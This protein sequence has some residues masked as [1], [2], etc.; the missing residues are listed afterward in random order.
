MLGNRNEMSSDDSSWSLRAL[1]VRPPTDD[2]WGIILRL[3]N[4]SVAHVPDAGP[5]DEWLENRR[6]FDRSKGTQVQ[7]VAEE[8]STHTILGYGA[9]ELRRDRDPNGCRLFVVAS[10]G[11]LSSVGAQ[12]FEHLWQSVLALHVARAWLTEYA[13]DVPL[14][15]FARERGFSEAARFWLPSGQ[16]AVTLVRSI[17]A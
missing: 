10:P 2:D 4:E 5:Q 12:L 9:V 3:A 11:D 13:S 8:P 16:E 7:L 14:Q 1:R 15:V 6:T 17:A